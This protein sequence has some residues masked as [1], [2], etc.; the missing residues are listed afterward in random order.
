MKIFSQMQVYQSILY[1][2]PNIN[3]KSR[4]TFQNQS[5]D[6]VVFGAMKKSDF[7]WIDR[8]CIDKFKAPIEKFKTNDHLQA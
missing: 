4:Y 6:T 1:Q 8:A 3:K 5:Y 2:Q 7:V